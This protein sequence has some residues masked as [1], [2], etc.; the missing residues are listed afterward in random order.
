MP[1]ATEHKRKR[2]HDSKFV[3]F[4]EANSTS[5]KDWIVTGLFYMALH[6]VERYLDTKLD[7]HCRSHSSRNQWLSRLKEF[8]P[9]WSDYEELRFMSEEARYEADPIES[10]DVEEAKDLLK[11]V[12]NHI[13]GLL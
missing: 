13:E 9:V 10:S 2:D 3:S 8:K 6:Q 5:F 1:S 7:K 11:T 12:E 4:V